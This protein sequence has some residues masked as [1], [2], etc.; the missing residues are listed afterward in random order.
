MRL[1][2]FVLLVAVCFARSLTELEYKKEFVNFV[3]KFEK[4]YQGIEYLERYEIFKDNLDKIEAINSQKLSWWAAVNQFTDLTRDEFGHFLRAQS[5][6]Y[7]P[8]MN[9]RTKKYTQNTGVKASCD[10]KDWVSEG[11]ITAVKNQGQCGSCWAFST[12]GAVEGRRAIANNGS[13]VSLSEMQLVDCSS[14]NNGCNGGLMD[15]AFEYIIS[16]GGLCSESDYPYTAP[17]KHWFCQK[18]NCNQVGKISS[19][20]D[21]AKNANS[22]KEAL[23]SGPVSV[24]IEAD[25]DAFQAYGG[26]LFDGTCGNQLDHGVLAVGFGTW[27]DGQSGYWKVKNSWGASWGADGYILIK[28]S[29][30][31]NGKVG[32]RCGIL[33][34][35]SYPIV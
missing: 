10:S 16:D 22:M 2:I 23:C 11:K 25:Q 13:P 32:D 4:T 19:Y 18:H 7:R 5:A 24:A 12:T 33:E 28:N 9:N 1:A 14:Q 26:G 17:P 31:A 34:S 8:H 20:Q 30:S 27:T 35:A 15:Y 29:D 6:G 21:V 3:E